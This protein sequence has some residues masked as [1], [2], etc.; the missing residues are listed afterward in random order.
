MTECWNSSSRNELW[1]VLELAKTLALSSTYPATPPVST[2]TIS[3]PKKQRKPPPPPPPPLSSKLDE[4][5][6]NGIT[7]EDPLVLPAGTFTTTNIFPPPRP[8]HAQVLDLEMALAAKE[9][10]LN[11]CGTMIDAAVNELTTMASAGDRFWTDVRR[12]K[13]GKWERG[14][15]AIVPRPDFGRVTGEGEKAKDVIIPYAIDEGG[16]FSHFCHFLTTC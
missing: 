14:Q 16:F 9:A 6:A 10:A 5:K 15:W 13:D 12:L 11:E 4:L 3:T 1:Y 8:L 7:A 2:A